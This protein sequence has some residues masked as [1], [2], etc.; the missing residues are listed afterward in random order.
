MRNSPVA[1]LLGN[2]AAGVEC[3]YCGIRMTPHLGSSRTVRYFRCATCHRWVST[4]YSEVFR[5]DAKVRALHPEPRATEPD[6]GAVKDRLE[7]WLASLDGQDPYR[8]MGVSPLDSTESIRA[9]YYELALERHPDRGGSAERMQELN[10]AYERIVGH[11][12]RRKTAALP[13]RATVSAV[14]L[15]ASSR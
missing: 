5:G 8:A 1:Q 13:A 4:T 14:P 11:R 3:T 12:D 2:E 15:P 7:R 9:R 10:A 6:F